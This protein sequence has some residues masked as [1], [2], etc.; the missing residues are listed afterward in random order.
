M[1]D[2]RLDQ[3]EQELDEILKK[4]EDDIG[5]NGSIEDLFESNDGKP[6]KNWSMDSIDEL[7]EG[8]E[9][10]SKSPQQDGY[11]NLFSET[12]GVAGADI[13]SISEDFF[14]EESGDVY[15]SKDSIPV[16][17]NTIEEAPVEFEDISSQSEG[18]KKNFVVN[19]D[20]DS[21]NEQEESA[22]TELEQP[23][24]AAEEN[25]DVISFF[26]EA[27]RGDGGIS[28]NVTKED[29]ALLEADEKELK[30]QKEEFRELD[31]N[32]L[33]KI[34]SQKDEQFDRGDYLKVKD[35]FKKSKILSKRRQQRA[36]AKSVAMENVKQKFGK[37]VFSFKKHKNSDEEFTELMND[38]QP[39]A[40]A[41]ANVKLDMETGEKVVVNPDEK[42]KVI[43][44]LDFSEEETRSDDQIEKTRHFDISDAEEAQIKK[45]DIGDFNNAYADDRRQ[46]VDEN[47]LTLQGFMEE[48]AVEQVSEQDVES[49][50]LFS[51]NE[52]KKR[53][54]LTNIPED[55]D[56]TD[57]MYFSKEK[58][59]YDNEQLLE[60]SDE[61]NAKSFK[62]VFKSAIKNRKENYLKEFSSKNEIP[63]IFKDL[64]DQR[65]SFIWSFLTLVVIEVFSILFTSYPIAQ[66]F[67][68][69]VA[70]ASVI[71]ILI[72]F[73]LLVLAFY[74]CSQIT[75][76][77]IRHILD[78]K[79]DSD[80]VLSLAIVSTM[81]YSLV[82]FFNLNE[83]KVTIPIFTPIIIFIL[84][85]Y[86]IA[87]FVEIST[88]IGNFKVLTKVGRDS[89]SSI[90]RIENTD[91]AQIL[92]RSYAGKNPN[93]RFS[94]SA[95]F[96]GRF[97]YNSTANHP[98][99]K[100]AKTRFVVLMALS[101]IISIVSAIVNK[102]VVALFATLTSCIC[103]C[104]PVSL[105]L[106][107]DLS[108]KLVNR[109]LNRKNSCITG[110]N[111]IHDAAHTDAVIVNA[112][113]L[114]DKDK[115][116]FYGMHEYGTIR[117]DDIVLYAAAM[118]TKSSGPLSHVFDKV[119]IGDKTELLPEVEDLLYEEKLGLSGWIQGQKILV[120]N[121]NLL[122]HHNLDAPAKSDEMKVVKDGNRVLYVAVD[123]HVAAMLVVSY[124]PDV[125]MQKYL[126]DLN[127]N[128][129]K[130][131]VG[132]ND[133]NVDEDVLSLAFGIPRENFKI[134]G[135]FDGGIA[136]QYTNMH[137]GIVSAKLV[138][139]F[140]S[141]SF[142]KCFS[143]AVLLGSTK[144]LINLVQSL[145]VIVGLLIVL[146]LSCAGNIM[147]LGSGAVVFYHVITSLI[148]CISVFVKYKFV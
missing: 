142:L 126:Q 86:C 75:Q 38:E 58:G 67:T 147:A 50:L 116:N 45:T 98:A 134:I 56:D 133:C 73:I 66:Q 60:L 77:G 25:D 120:G 54:K 52:R 106:S 97:L 131:I 139:D 32:Q 124:E 28:D 14:E 26:E 37:D 113:D 114:F 13:H 146:I 117:V 2:E 7:V 36:D 43:G 65:K 88:V 89:F 135:N 107:Y 105:L 12:Q 99:D 128:G 84:M 104:I 17:R 57:S 63:Q 141:E 109:V 23:S 148:L 136:S 47:Q 30:R 29:I 24:V 64:K 143:S 11:D 3:N 130:I 74:A 87:K 118:L 76:K 145:M 81:V 125:R 132:T 122:V 123:D 5:K 27:V 94:C 1:E 115:C 93:V 55:Y 100:F 19:I 96:P 92:A 44:E 21:E 53:F 129:I 59:K 35:I 22:E 108:L 137:K 18:F 20:Y 119:I 101:V 49:D 85:L 112:S 51:S 82:S 34:S 102:S 48:E 9:N 8:I 71:N 62:D 79:N 111:A 41:Q 42:T 80:A 78:R 40:Q 15:F 103:V 140:D 39:E 4:I 121:R 91:D 16:H 33:E 95:D 90:E 70:A 83:V 72:T 6:T 68:N 138:H 46:D 144:K 61:D 127:N 31:E 110:Y 69:S 10:E